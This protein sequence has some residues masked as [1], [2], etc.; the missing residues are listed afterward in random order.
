[1]AV[2]ILTR[3]NIEIG[4]FVNNYNRVNPCLDETYLEQRFEIF[5]RYTLQSIMDQT[6][7]DFKW[8]VLFHSETPQR[9]V[10]RIKKIKGTCSQFFP[11]FLPPET[12]S[13]YMYDVSKIIQADCPNKK[14]ISIRLDNDDVLHRLFVKSTRDYFDMNESIRVL[15]YINGLQYRISDCKTLTYSYPSN[16]FLS[17]C[18]DS[19]VK[20]NNILC[21]DHSMIEES[22]GTERIHFE[23]NY[24]PMWVEIISSTNVI[25]GMTWLPQRIVVPYNVIYEYPNLMFNWNSR[26]KYV[27][28]I[29][30]NVPKSICFVFLYMWRKIKR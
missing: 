23:D 17:M 6:D 25:N 1:M 12:G 13:S 20:E 10:D 18:M 21:Y 16:H 5:E 26:M 27:V 15:S 4:A 19:S 2:Y 24:T 28:E 7:Q 9:F 3:F 30:M 8:L 29:I 22:F 11:V 14:V